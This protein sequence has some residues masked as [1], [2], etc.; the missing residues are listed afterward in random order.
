MGDQLNK[1]RKMTLRFVIFCLI[2]LNNDAM[3]LTK[4]E[5]DKVFFNNRLS[6]RKYVM[7]G[8]DTDLAKQEKSKESRVRKDIQREEEERKQRLDVSKILCLT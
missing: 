7:G 1:L 4:I 5:E 8:V 6:E 2:L 3:N